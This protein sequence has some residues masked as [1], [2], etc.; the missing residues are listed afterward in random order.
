MVS[1]VAGSG[2]TILADGVGTTA[3]IY[4]PYGITFNAGTL[5]LAD[6]GNGKVR[7]VTTSGVVSTIVQSTIGGGYVDGSGSAARFN[8]VI[9]VHLAS[10]GN[11]FLADYSNHRIRKI[12]TSGEYLFIF[13]FSFFFFFYCVVS[14][15]VSTIAGCGLQ[16]YADGVGTSACF[17]SPRGVYLDLTGHLIVADN[18]N[19]RMRNIS[20]GGQLF[21]KSFSF[22]PFCGLFFVIVS[23]FR[24]G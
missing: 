21:F 18:A 2:S 17:S 5:Y 10:D 15:I 24:R 12:S 3:Y 19:H 1:T 13:L 14:G 4:R 8:N 22:F 11:L 7:K 6:Y 20:L 9:G 16:T 23:L